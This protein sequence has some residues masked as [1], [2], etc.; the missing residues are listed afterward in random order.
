ME[1][2]MRVEIK[3]IR[4]E[5]FG[6]CIELK[7]P[8]IETLVTLDFG[9]RI[10]EFKLHGS[11]NILFEDPDKTIREDHD[12]I[13]RAYGEDAVWYSFGGH[14]LWVAPEVMP[15]T[16]YPDGQRVDFQIQGNQLL[17]TP[18][19]QK[20]NQLQ[21]Q[22]EITMAEEAPEIKINHQVKNLGT[23]E[24][25]LA[26][27]AVTVLRPGGLEIIPMPEVKQGLL[28]N[29]CLAIWPYTD[30]GDERVAWGK[31]YITLKQKAMESKTKAKTKPFKFG[32]NNEAGWAAYLYKDFMFKKEYNHQKQAIYPD[33][34][35]SFETYT[36]EF[37]L[38]M[39]TLA[40]LRALKPGEAVIHE[41]IW[42]LSHNPEEFQ[43][44]L[45]KRKAL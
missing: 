22:M 30:M 33:L 45:A 4:H 20:E 19:P 40:P 43:A 12:K 21:L 23:V 42:S 16:Y 44:L 7:N 10:V 36:N 37:F 6:R 35:V 29:T 8:F 5:R 28:P 31:E 11:A 27:W 1:G 38:E 2:K 25:I 9:P 41:E 24:K 17:L 34:G 18:P 32:I 15:D 39:E 3:E 13:K 26:P 14:R